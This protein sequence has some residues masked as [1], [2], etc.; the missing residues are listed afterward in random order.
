MAFQK[1]TQS[2]LDILSILWRNGPMTVRQV[3]KLFKGKKDEVGYTTVLKF[4][5][6]MHEKGFLSR[7]T[8][9]RAHVYEAALPVEE[10]QSFLV[11]KMLDGPFLGSAKSLVLKALSENPSTPEE[12]DEIRQLIDQLSKHDA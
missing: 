7:D 9:A 12:L 10:M 2:E 5:Q 3:H 11:K 8:S 4:M 1:P 6:V